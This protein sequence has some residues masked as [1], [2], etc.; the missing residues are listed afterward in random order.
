MKISYVFIIEKSIALL[1]PLCH[2]KGHD[3]LFAAKIIFFKQ[4]AQSKGLKINT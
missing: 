2:E 1:Y 4:T 3:A